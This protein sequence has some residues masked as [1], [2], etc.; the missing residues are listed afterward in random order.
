MHKDS[1]SKPMPQ[2]GSLDELTGLV[3]NRTGVY[4]RWSLGPAADLPSVSS[5][6]DLTGIAMPG[7][8]A[9]AL[10]VEPWWGERS[11]RL[12]VARRLYDY[13]HLPRTKDRRV[14]PWLLLGTE[15]GRGPD[16][17][18]LVT[19]VRPV[20]WVHQAVIDEATREIEDQPGG[21]GPL[22][23]TPRRWH[24]RRRPGEAG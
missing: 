9:S 21:W 22:D 24:T 14:R 6:D 2:V 20:G 7:L 5:R 1:R 4:V 11:L 3:A 12:W 17:E 15:V 13:A 23:R 16:N 19:G 10:D 18:P 8:S